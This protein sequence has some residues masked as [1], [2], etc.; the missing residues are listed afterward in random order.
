EQ[1]A[2][3]QAGGN[4]HAGVPGAPPLDDTGGGG[5]MGGGGGGAV[6][7]EQMGLPAPDRDRPIDASKFLAGTIVLPAANQGKVPSGGAIFLAVRPADASGN[8]AGMP[9]A[10]DRLVASGTWPLSFRITEAQAMVGGI[11]F[12]GPVVITARYDQDGEARS[13]Q[14]GDI[15][16][17]VQ[18]TIPADNLVINLDTVQQ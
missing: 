10:V 17:T 13:H 15:S 1:I 11:P 16:G 12:A 9:M 2:A 5:A 8:A 3:A 18:A 6:P 14:P 7:V 4:P